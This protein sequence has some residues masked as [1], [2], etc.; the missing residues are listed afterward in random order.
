M[1][2]CQKRLT[3]KQ[4][5]GHVARGLLHCAMAKK[6]FASL[7]QSLRKVLILLCAML[8]ATQ[9]VHDFMIARRVQLAISLATYV[10]TK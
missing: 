4:I 7:R 9:I 10:A 2:A 5:A 6:L 3:R 8:L 1:R